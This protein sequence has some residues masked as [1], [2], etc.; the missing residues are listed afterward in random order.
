MRSDRGR[1]RVRQDDGRVERVGWKMSSQRFVG[2]EDCRELQ[3][4]DRTLKWMS[5]G[6]FSQ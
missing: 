5:S 1:E 3:I 2:W 4:R 6:I